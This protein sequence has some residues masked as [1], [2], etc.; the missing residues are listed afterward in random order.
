[1]KT[2]IGIGLAL[3]LAAAPSA[4]AQG[5]VATV[6]L[7]AGEML[8]EL[9]SVGSAT[10]RAD[11]A[12]VTVQI[13]LQGSDEA[14]LRRQYD[15]IVARL[16]TAARDS[17]G[18]IRVDELMSY[19]DMTIE[20][21]VDYELN[22]ALANSTVSA[23]SGYSGASAA[24][25][26]LRDLSRI[27]ALAR[28]LNGIEGIYSDTAYRASDLSA[29]RRQA[30]DNAIAAARSEADSYA[31]SL[32]M[33][34]ARMA[35]VTER[36]DVDFM[37]MMMGDTSVTNLAMSAAPGGDPNIPAHVRVGVDFILAAR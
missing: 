8:L 2:S 27:E 32:G 35:R 20:N 16:R 19:S 12:E 29:V 33:R 6:P 10:G 5:P 24:V 3:L 26:R 36:V 34:V 37:A 22:A 30:R 23:I 4:S 1:M 18:D 15:R 21:A 31:A 11:S 13:S 7:A 17:G 9:N 28:T 25:I 14:D